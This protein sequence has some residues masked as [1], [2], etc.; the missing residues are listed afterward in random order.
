MLAGQNSCIGKCG[1]VRDTRRRNV[2]RVARRTP[3]EEEDQAAKPSKPSKPAAKPSAASKKRSLTK[4]PSF[5]APSPFGI[6]EGY[7]E[8]V[9]GVPD[10]WRYRG[11][12]DNIIHYHPR[13]FID[14][15]E[16]K[17]KA[18]FLAAIKAIETHIRKDNPDAGVFIGYKGIARSRLTGEGVG[19]G[20]FK[21][22][23]IKW[24]QGYAEHYIRDHNVMPSKRLFEHIMAHPA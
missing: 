15:R 3:E 10:T 17:G 4:P 24:P 9:E 5:A 19:G 16:W 12:D 13:D 22:H 2:L 1:S 20:E 14:D 6:A 11:D 18:A 7:W 23:G 21:W 8:N